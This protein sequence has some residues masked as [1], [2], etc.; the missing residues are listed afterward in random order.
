MGDIKPLLFVL[1]GFLLIV[2]LL[3]AIFVPFIDEGLTSQKYNHPLLDYTRYAITG[4]EYLNYTELQ[5]LTENFT[6]WDK[7]KMWFLF[8]TPQPLG[9]TGVPIN[10]ISA[11]NQKIIP[12]PVA[13]FL[14]TQ[15]EIISYIPGYI[16]YP[17]LIFAIV[18]IL[19]TGREILGFT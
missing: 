17:L 7:I 6:T 11:V 3:N 19:W 2:A 1:G 13:E 16:L 15:F 8:N 9:V 5:N 10:F 18:I 14:D 12:S 4:H